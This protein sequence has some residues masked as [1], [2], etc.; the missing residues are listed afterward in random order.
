VEAG[1]AKADNSSQRSPEEEAIRETAESFLKAYAQADGKAAAAHFTSNAEYIDDEGNV[2]EG[3]DEIEKNFSR[4]F[5]EN[6]GA[7]LE[8]NIESIRV[9]HPGLAVEDGTTR[10]V[11]DDGTPLARSRYVAVHVKADGKWLVATVREHAPKGERPHREQLEQLA[12]LVGEWMDESD[13]S[14]VTFVCRPV[15]DGNFL[16]RDFTVTVAGEEVLHGSQRIGW[17]PM[18]G[19]LRAWTF[20]SQGGHFE[21]VWHRDGDSWVLNSTGVTADGQTASGTSIFTLVDSRTITW[22]AVNHE[23]EGERKPDSELY[24]LVRRGPLPEMT[25]DD[26]K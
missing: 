12:W 21:G 26:S 6:K 20:D 19:R 17:D 2:F 5:A 10:I 7:Q 16:V 11:R 24:T 14:I 25:A 23:V 22:Q 13:E 4:F 9:V 15:D 3:R 1:S 8:I 18:T